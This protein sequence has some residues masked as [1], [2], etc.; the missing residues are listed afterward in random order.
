MINYSYEVTKVLLETKAVKINVK[1]PFIFASGIKSPI[2]CDNRYILGF[3]EYRNIVLNGILDAIKED[4]DVIAGVAT[5]GIPWASLVADKLFK[6]LSYIRTKPKGH[7]SGKLIEGADVKGK[8]ILLI[9]DLITTGN[10]SLVAVENLKKEGASFIKVLSIFSYGFNKAVENYAKYDV[11]FSS[12]S[13]FNIL[14]KLL[15][16]DGYLSNEE[17]NVALKWSEDPENWAGIK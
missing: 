2:Y 13:N 4:V 8:R 7:G 6:P 9:E 17:A 12:V 1:D 16:E 11:E 15:K 14:I 10:S 3:P 5:A